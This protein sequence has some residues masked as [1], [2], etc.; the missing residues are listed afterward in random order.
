MV[1]AGA[2]ML[3]QYS[4]IAFGDNLL[5]LRGGLWYTAANLLGIGLGAVFRF[6]SYRRGSGR[7]RSPGPGPAAPRRASSPPPGRFPARLSPGPAGRRTAEA[8]G[9]Y[10]ARPGVPLSCPDTQRS[11]AA[12]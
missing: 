12:T 3:I 8:G 7:R 10:P 1:L 4:C 9:D 6:W 11:R 5:L 2:D